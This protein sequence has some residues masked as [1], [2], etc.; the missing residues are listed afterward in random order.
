MI[1]TPKQEFIELMTENMK[2][3]GLDELSSKVLAVLFVEPSEISLEDLALRTGYS[4]S[5]ISTSMKFIEATG[6]V[7]KYKKPNSR[8]IFL[9]MDK[10]ILDI[11]LRMLKRKQENVIQKSR[12]ILPSIIDHYKKAKASKEE[13]KIIENYYQEVLLGEKLIKEFIEKIEHSR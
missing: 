12:D 8:K 3:N 10:S 6:L 11:M 13:L 9:H 7:N 2:A 5:T 1:K 4:L